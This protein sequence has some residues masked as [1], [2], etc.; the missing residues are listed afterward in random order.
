MTISSGCD[1]T[2]NVFS[3]CAQP[4][5]TSNDSTNANTTLRITIVF[6]HVDFEGAELVATA[7]KNLEIAVCR[8]KQD[9]MAPAQCHLAGVGAE[10]RLAAYAHYYDK[11][12]EVT[13]ATLYAVGCAEHAD[14]EVWRHADRRGGIGLGGVVQGKAAGVGVVDGTPG[15]LEV[16]P[17]PVAIGVGAVVVVETESVVAGLLYLGDEDAGADGVDTSAGM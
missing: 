13:I 16:E 3:C 10:G 11:G 8:R 17:A 9:S 12:I 15:L 2:M 7:G 1:Q 5:R 4:A 6:G 14:S